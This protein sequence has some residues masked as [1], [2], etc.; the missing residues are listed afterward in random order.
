MEILKIGTPRTD[1]PRN[2]EIHYDHTNISANPFD[3]IDQNTESIMNLLED[4]NAAPE[5]NV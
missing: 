5:N 1:I 2:T 3:L 4:K